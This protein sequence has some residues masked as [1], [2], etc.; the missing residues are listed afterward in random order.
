MN[1]GYPFVSVQ[2]AQKRVAHDTD[3]NFLFHFGCFAEEKYI[4]E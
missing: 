3:F 2:Q 4:D 1:L